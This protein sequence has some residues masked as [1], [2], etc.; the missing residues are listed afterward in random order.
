MW[1]AAG[2]CATLTSLSVTGG[3]FVSDGD[4]E[5]GVTPPRAGPMARPRPVPCATALTSLTLANV[6]CSDDA[7]AQLDAWLGQHERLASL[8]VLG[9]PNLGDWMARAL[10]S[11]PALTSLRVESVTTGAEFAEALANRLGHGTKRS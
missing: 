6:D 3:T 8:A 7:C 2:R 9:C 5:D 10:L 11:L 4:A 1:R